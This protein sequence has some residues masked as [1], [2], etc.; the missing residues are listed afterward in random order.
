MHGYKK[1]VPRAQRHALKSWL[2]SRIG[3][4]TQIECLWTPRP[5]V[6][7]TPPRP[8][9]TPTPPKPP[10]TPTPLPG[11]QLKENEKNDSKGR[12]RKK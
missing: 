6:T 2:L 4:L 12:S 8:P 10:V 9:M 3:Y 5:T 1:I 7:P 11:T